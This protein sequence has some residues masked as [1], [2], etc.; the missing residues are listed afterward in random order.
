MTKPDLSLEEVVADHLRQ[1]LSGNRLC[2][3]TSN[4]RERSMPQRSFDAA[5][6]AEWDRQC[7]AIRAKM[8]K[9]GVK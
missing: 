7:L 9:R 3:R 2:P 1:Y 8:F 5:Y 6:I 4:R